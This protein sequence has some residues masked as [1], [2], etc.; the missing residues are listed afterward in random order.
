MNAVEGATW[1]PGVWGRGRE[2]PPVGERVK[3]RA[4]QLLGDK[5]AEERQADAQG[6]GHTSRTKE[7]FT[8]ERLTEKGDSGLG[9]LIYTKANRIPLA[10]TDGAST[11]QA[12]DNARLLARP[13][14]ARPLSLSKREE[15][16]GREAARRGLPRPALGSTL[17]LI[18]VASLFVT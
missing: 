4:L 2:G 15:N 12:T 13:Y 18:L 11:C 10:A 6:S 17:T 5:P 14:I 16:V 3:A 1:A 8:G 9:P 7:S